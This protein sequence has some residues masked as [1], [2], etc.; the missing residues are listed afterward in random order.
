MSKLSLSRNK[1]GTRG[2]LTSTQANTESTTETLSRE[3]LIFQRQLE[4]ALKKS[5]EEFEKTI[6]VGDD[7]DP[8]Q[9]DIGIDE[10]DASSPIRKPRTGKILSSD[11]EN[12]G[13]DDEDFRP[14]PVKKLPESKAIQSKVS[15][16][17]NSTSNLSRLDQPSNPVQPP[18]PAKAE[19]T[20]KDPV[21]STSGSKRPRNKPAKYKL[22]DSEESEASESDFNSCDESDD[23]FYA[24]SSKKKRVPQK[25]PVD[26]PV[27]KSQIL[28]KNQKNQQRGK[29]EPKNQDQI[30]K[31]STNISSTAQQRTSKQDDAACKKENTMPER[32]TKSR[33]PAISNSPAKL[34]ASKCE[35]IKSAAAALNVARQNRVLIP[36]WTPPSLVIKNNGSNVSPQTPSPSIG[37]RVGLSRNFKPSKPLHANFKYPD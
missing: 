19:V 16:K 2:P 20:L 7:P 13:Q 36:K 30:Q 14:S 25:K 29:D 27:K 28:P 6:A 4:A 34:P 24:S 17:P 23:E 11:D 9:V 18:Q 12:S 21:P 3:E 5:Q 33:V 10:G 1:G 32:S 26:P 37:M 15:P 31:K 8:K 22:S 35:P